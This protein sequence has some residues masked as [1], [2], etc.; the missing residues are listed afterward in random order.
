LAKKF[1][2]RSILALIMDFAKV[3]PVIALALVMSAC[4]RGTAAGSVP[5]SMFIITPAQDPYIQAFADYLDRLEEKGLESKIS[6]EVEKDAPFLFL[7]R[8][9]SGQ[10]VSDGE[11]TEIMEQALITVNVF[12]S[13]KG[14]R[15]E[16]IDIPFSRPA[17]QRIVVVKDNNM[18]D[19]LDS[20]GEFT[21]SVDNKYFTS[22][23]NLAG[24][25]KS[26]SQEFANTWAVIQAICL[27]YA[28]DFEGL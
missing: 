9:L 5:T 26:G 1:T 19:L 21:I 27:A 20:L 22:I 7:I 12:E 6:I 13:R 17:S 3:F 16:D 4:E 8:P 10:E 2:I 25:A 28:G 18:P 14:L 24:P 11:M 23:V 15:H